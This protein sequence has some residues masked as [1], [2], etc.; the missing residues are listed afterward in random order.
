MREA[1]ERIEIKKTQ[2]NENKIQVNELLADI[3][4]VGIIGL[5]LYRMELLE[6]R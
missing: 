1:P 2:F 5:E 6:K 4:G 3:Y